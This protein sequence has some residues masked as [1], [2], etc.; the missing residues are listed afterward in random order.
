MCNVNQSVWQNT[1]ELLQKLSA[2]Q[3]LPEAF[4]GQS[5]A[6]KYIYYVLR[7]KTC[8]IYKYVQK[9]LNMRRC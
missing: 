1:I 4:V 5:H 7:F 2:K 3:R 6:A 9:S 8:Q